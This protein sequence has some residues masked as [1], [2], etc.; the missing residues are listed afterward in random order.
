M[1]LLNVNREVQD[2]FYRYKMPS[3]MAK[4][5]GKG[6]GVK[7]VIV[8]M[9]DIGRAIGR[10]ASYPCKFFGCE[11]GAQTQ[12]DL[13]NDRYIVNG[14]HEG[15]RLQ[16]MLDVF[17]KKFVLCQECDNPETNMV[18]KRETIGLI[19][20]ACGNQSKV[21]LRHKLCTYIIRNPPPKKS[22]A[23]HGQATEEKKDD[24]VINEPPQE[25]SVS[26]GFANDGWSVDVSDEAVA[27]RMKEI[28]SGAANL[29]LSDD[30][31]RSPNE[32]ADMLYAFINNHVKAGTV[33]QATVDICNEAQRL[34][35]KSKAPLILVELLCDTNMREQLKTHKDLFVRICKG[36]KKAQKAML[37]GFEKMVEL[38]QSKLLPK[39]AHIV[40]DFYDLDI[41]DEEILIEWGTRIGKRYVSKELSTAIHKKAEPVIVWLQEADEES[42]E[43]ESED[44]DD[45]IE[46]EYDD[47]ASSLKSESKYAKVEAGSGDADEEKPSATGSNGKSNDDDDDFDID[48][49]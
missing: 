8:N 7:T 2:T 44:D 17:I 33:K 23:S 35:M 41:V 15:S 20:K 42:S 36:N 46:I 34:D 21:D 48:D 10:P 16:D 38:H 13:K 3:I 26:N 40:K 24:Q 27:H 31:E 32:R 1:S 25:K 43:E 28:T 30:L 5:E 19:C 37:G 11:L 49:I 6:N 4:V 47:R 29:T 45:E 9:S 39:V 14:S 22:K 12:F 18:V